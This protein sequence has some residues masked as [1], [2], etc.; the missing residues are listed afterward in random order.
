MILFSCAK[1]SKSFGINPVLDQLSFSVKAGS[2]LG[3]V[4][5]NGAGK[6]TLF[7]LITGELSSDEGSLYLAKDT[8]IGCLKQNE[9]VSSSNTVWEEMLTVFAPVL[10]MEKRIQFLEQKISVHSDAQNPE[11]QELTEEYG[12]LLEQFDEKSGYIYQSLMRGVLT[13][14]G[15]SLEEFHQ[16]IWQL[17]GGQKTRVALAKLLLEKPSLLLLDEPTNHLDL[18]SVQWLEGFLKDY[19]GTIFIISHDRF[20]L[21]SLCD[22]ILEIEN[23]NGCLYQGNYSEYHK[24]K[25]QN[26]EIQLKEYRQQQKEIRRQEEIIQRFR[27]FN[28]E[29]SIRAAES[30]QR[31]LNKLERVDKP[32]GTQDVRMSF[33]VNKHS[34]NDVLRVEG[35]GMS[36]D[37]RSLFENVSFSL[38][39]GD[40]VGIIGPNGVGKTTLFRILLGKLQPSAGSIH[41]GTGVDIGYYDQEQSSLTP[42]KSVINELWDVFPLLSETQIRSTLALFLFRGDD[43]YKPI[44]QLSGG[45]RGR[46]ML[47]KLMLAGNN[48]LLLDEPTNHLDMASKEVLE[49]SLADY[50]GTMLI[51]SHDRYFLNKIVDRILEF[52]ENGVTEYQGNYNDYLEKKKSQELLLALSEQEP[53]EK[54]RT[55]QKEERRKERQ[56]RQKRKAFQ[57]LL[58]AAEENI[59]ALEIEVQELETTLYDPELYQDADKMLDIQQQ[60]NQK[61][62]T[63]NAAYEEWLKL[64]DSQEEE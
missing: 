14:L 31:A 5:S 49:E 32:V 53:A 20:F 43:V 34:G 28:R 56:E 2:C 37:S 47:S 24:R 8:T 23:R 15:F 21:D 44:H 63:L 16:P 45:E 11:Y 7:K 41:Y 62:T 19:P 52:E 42:E 1:L 58:K 17:S 60:Y 39:K 9:V 22:C 35:L 50:T 54:T 59:H 29:K 64:H 33:H 57:Q 61:K 6:T 48:F 40:R 46:V 38:E 55:A 4:G 36:F 3:I 30:R 51:I 10:E 27:S 26:R 13:G 18:E 12:T 25:Q